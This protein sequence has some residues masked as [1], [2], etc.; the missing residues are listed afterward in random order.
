MYIYQ[1]RNFESAVIEKNWDLR[2]SKL[3]RYIHNQTDWYKVSTRHSIHPILTYLRTVINTNQTDWDTPVVISIFCLW[4]RT[5][6]ANRHS[7]W[8]T[9]AWTSNLLW[10]LSVEIERNICDDSSGSLTEAEIWE[11]TTTRPIAAGCK[12]VTGFGCIIH[13]R[14]KKN[15]QDCRSPGRNHT[16][17]L[18]S[19][20]TSFRKPH[21]VK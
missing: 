8:W 20:L 16:T 21:L 19:R 13:L 3:H 2:E 1:R 9:S 11:Q 17:V 6:L 15:R 12:W 5:T 14:R 18:S 10:N 7:V 4:K